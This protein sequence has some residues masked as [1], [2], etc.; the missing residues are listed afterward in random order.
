MC[1]QVALSDL[2]VAVFDADIL[3]F[4][5][6]Y[7][8]IH[9]VCDKLRGK[10]KTTATAVSLVKVSLIISRSFGHFMTT[11]YQKHFQ[12]KIIRHKVKT[13][14]LVNILNSQELLIYLKKLGM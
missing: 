11:Q 7:Q 1:G 4:V 13:L 10:V 6:P 5:V 2:D 9:E 14:Q 12:L 3:V 8:Y